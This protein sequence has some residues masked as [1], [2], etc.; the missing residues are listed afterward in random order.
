MH[1]AQVVRHHGPETYIYTQAH[2]Q[3]MS[4]MW[5]WRTSTSGP[6]RVHQTHKDDRHSGQGTHADCMRQ[7]SQ[8]ICDMRDA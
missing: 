6:S 5:G 4:D 7:V 3:R 2:R 8:I 1:M